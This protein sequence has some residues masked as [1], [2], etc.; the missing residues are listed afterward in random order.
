LKTSE[1]NPLSKATDKEISFYFALQGS[2]TKAGIRFEP[3]APRSNAK[4]VYLDAR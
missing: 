3:D 2:G 1:V 4:I